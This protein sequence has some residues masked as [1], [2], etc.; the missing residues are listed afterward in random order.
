MMTRF[1]YALLLMPFLIDGQL[2]AQEDPILAI[3]SEYDQDVQH[4]LRQFCFDCHSGEVIEAELDMS[5]FK[6]VADIQSNIKPWIRISAMLDSRQMPPKESGQPTD[7][8]R[9]LL[10]KWTKSLLEH[11]AQKYAGDPGPV[12][13]RRLNNSEYDYT[14][15]D[16]TGIGSLNPTSEFPV[17][18]AAGEG[19]INT[20]DALSMSPNL[21]RKYLDAGKSVAEHAVFTPTGIRWSENT[22]RRN[23]V[24]EMMDQI[25][26]FY[27]K[28]N[29]T[30]EDT[31]LDLQGNLQLRRYLEAIANDRETLLKQTQTIEEV[32]AKHN[33][34]PVY[35]QKL[36]TL[37]QTPAGNQHLLNYLSQR[38]RSLTAEN[39][40]PLA[41]ELDAWQSMLWT[42]NLVGHIG[43]PAAPSQW[44]APVNPLLPVVELER[45]FPNE[46]SEDV[47]IYLGA[48]SAG[49]GD[50]TDY[51][52]WKN[53]R[54]EKEG[55][56]PIYL[57]NLEGVS[58]RYAE[59]QKNLLS[60]TSKYLAAV[61]EA[62]KLPTPID[63]E[64]LATKHN[65]NSPS[66]EKWLELMNVR[67]TTAVEI[68]GLILSQVKNV[69]GYATVNGW[70]AELPNLTANHSDDLVKI[71]G[72]SH[73]H[74]ITVHPT[75]DMYLA[76]LWKA[77]EDVR[78]S[79][80]ALVADAHSNCGNGTEFWLQHRAGEKIQELWHGTAG[81]RES[82][83]FPTK[84][85]SVRK[86]E[87]I[88]LYIGPRDGE[89]A[90]DLTRI[91][92]T[93][94]ELEGKQREWDLAR[95]CA[96]DILAGN[97]HADRL[98]NPN[99][100]HITKGLVTELN[101]PTVR[102][103]SLP[104]GTILEAWANE[105]DSNKRQQLAAEIQAIINGP[106]PTE[107]Q[108]SEG[109]V[110]QALIGLADSVVPGDLQE[111]VEFDKRF[112]VHPVSGEV[113]KLDLVS[114]APSAVAIKIPAL[115]ARGRTLKVSGLPDPNHGRD[116]TVQLHLNGD[117][118][119]H[120]RLLVTFPILS[121][122]GNV[123]H[124]EMV[125]TLNE[126]RELFPRA[127]AYV[128]LVP[129]DEVVPLVLW[130]REDHYLQKLML[131]NKQREELDALWDEFL[132][133]AQ[134][135][136]K[137][138]VSYEQLYQFATQDRPDI[139]EDLKP[140]EVNVKAHAEGFRKRLLETEPVH[141]KAVI[142][143]AHT[144][145]RRDLQ[146]AERA[147]IHQLYTSLREV[148]LQHE[149]AC[150][151]TIAR[152]LTSPNFLFKQENA[153][154]GVD[155]TGVT[156]SE[157]AARLSYFLW[158]SQ[159]DEVLR[160]AAR[161][162]QLDTPQQIRKQMHRMLLDSRTSRIA[163]E[164]AAQWLH[165]RNFNSNNDKNE[166]LYPEFAELREDMYQEILQFFDDLFRNNGSV[167]NILNADY[168]FLNERLAKHYG[169]EGVTGLEWRR[170]DNVKQAGRGGILGMST[171]LATNSGAS[172]T[173][174]IL[175]GNWVYETLLGERLPKPPANVPQLPE[176]V[177]E[178]KTARELIE[179]HSSV[180]ECAKCHALIDP[181]GFALEQ[182]DVLGRLRP[183]KIDTRT[184]LIDDTELDG[185]D[186]LRNYL[187]TK[188]QDDFLRQFCK[189]LLG[190][191]LGREVQLS[192]KPL[193]DTMV[194]QL[195][196]NDYRINVAITQIV[197][198]KQFRYIRGRDFATPE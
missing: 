35:L 196:T 7:N 32:S 139:V 129:V 65:L 102:I 47:T 113:A 28:V 170:V 137:Y 70:G 189:K 98:G 15:Q 53:A 92:L 61:D 22:T 103:S 124:D 46:L 93:L 132:F 19:F 48:S 140:I 158:S 80:T 67:A 183:N 111:G 130:Y 12:V 97:P 169:I 42:F 128:R 191:S 72:D 99:I 25:R 59:I 38:L 4:L 177:P 151:L 26:D 145:W 194:Q 176:F 120:N 144:A 197:M 106:A 160:E 83:E 148:G 69:A 41:V 6:S 153:K 81:L 185:I 40:D 181:Y 152:I 52:L 156:S 73:P 195:K 85:M 33:V 114:K 161:H 182:Y 173:S 68:Q 149:P 30:T 192:D 155:A 89:H 20:G 21:I 150:R 34:N 100:W 131:T 43:R 142:D 2:Q 54:L 193:I 82:K 119:V 79:V 76:V 29:R 110:Y 60:N 96:N 116:A 13:L 49:D 159:P 27:R 84:E 190:Y 133:V 45:Q 157:I 44:Q 78:V 3:S 51:V 11:E 62:S 126:F 94:K 17:D 168:T 74:G 125:N 134:E 18:G 174:P 50:E 187:V 105:T 188:R 75:P 186:G 23:V 172:R 64:A 16:L 178:G 123:F 127:L 165:V 10:Q 154:E 95:D 180:A 162:N 37:H 115:F 77:P 107:P 71:P 1:I 14:V 8:Q 36:W 24:D 9:E 122:P 108:S 104:L 117:D 57:A 87:V 136:L 55:E 39:I 141:L 86:G 135:P 90:C 163:T 66:L 5:L 146:A 166:E 63:I 198:S 91:D 88:G 118:S 31:A 56:P 138:E 121:P 147:E 167:L 175:R 112:G 164:F 101:K 109:R 58:R 184:T 179:L 143:F 171:T